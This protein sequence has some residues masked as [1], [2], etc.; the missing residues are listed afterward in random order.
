VP[1]RQRPF[2]CKIHK[3]SLE[4]FESQ[5]ILAL[6]QSSTATH[7]LK[8]AGIFKIFERRSR[9]CWSNLQW[10]LPCPFLFRPASARRERKALSDISFS[11]CPLALDD[12]SRIG[13]FIPPKAEFIPQNRNIPSAL[14]LF[15]IRFI[16][17]STGNGWT[18]QNLPLLKCKIAH[19]QVKEELQS[20]AFKKSMVYRLE[21]HSQMIILAIAGNAQSLSNRS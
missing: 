19:N 12:W 21:T 4:T 17:S 8:E 11:Y 3:S 14:D 6:S 10:Q 5:V 15:K 18:D 16:G 20:I 7:D 13:G 1:F 2:K 9:F